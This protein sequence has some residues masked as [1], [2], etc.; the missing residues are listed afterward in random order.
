MIQ[1]IQTIYL[2]LAFVCVVLLL[3]F[4][5]FSVVAEANKDIPAHISAEFGAYGLQFTNTIQSQ[6]ELVMG[7]EVFA[8]FATDPEKGSFPVYVVYI[9]LALFTAASI[10]L[11]K[12]RKRQ[13]MVAR[14][15][16]LFHTITVIGVYAFYYFG[17]GAIKDALPLTADLTITF[18]LEPGFYLILATIPFLLLAIRGIKHDENLVKSLDRLR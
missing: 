8:D 1:R 4:P 11:Y 2:L 17:T 18:G 16:F 13:L 6:H 14:F 15:S 7:E 10:L 3:F 5:L 12:K 9:I